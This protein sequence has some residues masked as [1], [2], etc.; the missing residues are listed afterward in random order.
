[1][2][3]GKGRLLNVALSMTAV[4][5]SLV[6]LEAGLRAWVFIRKETRPPENQTDRTLYVMSDLPYLY[7]LNPA[8][9][10]ISTQGLRD[11]EFAVPKPAGVHR[12]LVLGDSVTY[13]VFVAAGQSFPKQ[14]ERRLEHLRDP[15]IE[16]INS[17]VAGYTP[18]TELQY[19]LHRGR[20]FGAD[21]VVVAFVM[22]DIVNPRR[23][24]NYPGAIRNIPEEAI[25]N[26]EYDRKYVLPKLRPKPKR[27]GGPLE[28]S[29]LYGLVRQRWELLRRAGGEAE[30]GSD[31]RYT[32]VAGKR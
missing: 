4:L 7:G 18:Y 11:R 10:S 31:L 16:V 22:N 1:M 12:I 28:H 8:H 29:L 27:K 25:P 23:H 20:A 21:T 30:S 3:V 14:L 15:R 6:L 13:G 19:Y 2:T 32:I 17:G 24:V 5:C 9:P 26:L